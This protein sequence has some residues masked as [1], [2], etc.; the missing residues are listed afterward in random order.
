MSASSTHVVQRRSLAV[1]LCLL[2]VVAA[3]TGLG[4]SRDVP[5]RADH[6][7]ATPVGEIDASAPA[8]SCGIR[9]YRVE[10]ADRRSVRVRWD[11]GALTSDGDEERTLQTLTLGARTYELETKGGRFELRGAANDVDARLALRA[12]MAVDVDMAV[13]GSSL[14]R[15]GRAHASCTSE[16]LRAYSCAGRERADAAC[17]ASVAV[18]GACMVQWP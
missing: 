2:A 10:Q 12:F 16:C 1:G 17:E 9:R 8:R 5:P 6:G 18:C 14:V 4:R 15:G 13:Q 7:A 11:G 3:S